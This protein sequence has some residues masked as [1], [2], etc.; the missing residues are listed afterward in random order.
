MTKTISIILLIIQ[1]IVTLISMFYCI[2]MIIFDYK[3]KKEMKDFVKR[4]PEFKDILK[5][6]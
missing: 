4:N 2:K 6:D 1:V 5:D 3:F